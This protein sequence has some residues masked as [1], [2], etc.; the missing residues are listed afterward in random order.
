VKVLVGK[1]N[2]YLDMCHRNSKH[3]VCG[4]FSM[5]GDLLNQIIL[6]DTITMFFSMEIEI[7]L[8]MRI[9]VLD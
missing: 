8:S 7:S 2:K 9:D 1:L 5:W 3:F 4:S 6:A